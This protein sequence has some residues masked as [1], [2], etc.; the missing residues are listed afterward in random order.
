M[1]VEN[2]RRKKNLNV[3]NWAPGILRHWRLCFFTA[4]PYVEPAFA[5]VEPS[6]EDEVHGVVFEISEEQARGLD[7]QEAGYD[8]VETEVVTYDGRIVMAGVYKT[9]KAKP[10]DVLPSLRYARLLKKGAQE[11]G[12]CPKYA[13][14]LGDK[15]Y[16]TPPHVR[17]VTL[18]ALRECRDQGSLREWTLDEVTANEEQTSVGGW[19]VRCRAPFSSWRGH[20]ITRRN[21]VHFRGFSVD[22]CDIRFP[23]EGFLPIPRPQSEEEM[24]YL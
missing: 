22:T 13:E 10:E 23:N 11:A 9:K 21:L 5:M 8:V 15:Y 16:V 18:N 2:M 24:E 19:V 7:K 17:A 4:I 1:S 3:L 14:S 6:H 20:D 12:L